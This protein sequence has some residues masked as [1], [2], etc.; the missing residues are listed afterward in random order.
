MATFNSPTTSFSTLD[1]ESLITHENNPITGASNFFEG[2][3][4]Q[5]LLPRLFDDAASSI[6]PV[7]LKSGSVTTAP[8]SGSSAPI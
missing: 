6:G 8:P 7:A 5:L 1:T 4:A 2:E 3:V